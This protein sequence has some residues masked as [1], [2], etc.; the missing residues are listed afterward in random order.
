MAV[1]SGW[2]V[3]HPPLIFPE[4]GRGKE[5]EIKATVA[6]FREAAEVIAGAAPDTVVIIS[7]HA[8]TYSDYFQ[9]SPGE[10][11]TGDMRSFGV[12]GVKVEAKFD[13]DFVRALS[14]ECTADGFPAGTLGED[15]KGLDHAASI[16]VRFINEAA[17]GNAASD[18]TTDKVFPK[19]VLAGISGLPVADQYLFGQYIAKTAEALGRKTVVVASGDLSHK[20]K[21]EGPYGYAKEGPAFDRI[22]CEIAKDADFSRLLLMD[23]AFLEKAGECGHRPLV[24]MAGA[25]DRKSVESK[26]YSY[27]GPFGVG[28]CVASFTV[29]GNDDNRDF[30]DRYL[31]GEKKRAADRAE[32]ESPHVTLARSTVENYIKTGRLYKEPE[33]LPEVLKGEKAGVFVCIKK[34][35]QLRGCIGTI[36][37]VTDCIGEEIRANAVSAATRDPRFNAIEEDELP[38]LEYTVDVLAPAEPIKSEDELDPERYGVIVSLGAKR[39][40]L[41]PNLDGIEDVDSQV[42]IALQK[43]GISEADR[44][45]VRLERFEVVRYK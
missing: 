13:V 38:Y 16:P 33:P 25:L 5:K 20:L 8:R 40:L 21:Y 9:I 10:G 15:T 31:D 24:V 45:Q 14:L 7:P 2:L 4:V 23:G 3:P 32:N 1:I 26:L 34:Q 37:P 11:A 22:I 44:R 39:G 18:K 17:A 19:Y 27:E 28:Y 6:A 30:A 29:T 42:S 41:L 12:S 43:A 36:S 35:G